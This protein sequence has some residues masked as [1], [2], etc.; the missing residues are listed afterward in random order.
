MS[1]ESSFAENV[2]KLFSVFAGPE[3]PKEPWWKRFLRWCDL[4][5]E[6]ESGWLATIKRPPED[7]EKQ[8]AEWQC[9]MERWLIQAK[10]W[11]LGEGHEQGN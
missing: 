2:T 8:I 1:E 5:E 10:D 9:E 3:L 4:L 11:A 6:R 7:S